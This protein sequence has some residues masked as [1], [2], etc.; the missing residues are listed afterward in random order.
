ML[1]FTGCVKDQP[2]KPAANNPGSKHGVY[3]VCEGQYSAGD[4]SLYVYQPLHDSVFGDLYFNANSKPLGDV[5]QSMEK[6]GDNFFLA[7]NNSNKVAVVTADGAKLIATINIPFPRYILP[8]GG[9]K[10]YV[11]TLYSN[12]IYVINTGSYSVA[13]SISL[14]FSNGEG[15][16][17]YDNYAFICPWDT[18]CSSV[19]KVDINT[20]QIVQA[21]SV[22]GRA[23]HSVLLD[24]ERMLWVLSGNQPK[25]KAA[26]WTKIDPSTGA[27]LRVYNF[28]GDAEP[29]KPALNPTKDTIY[30]IGVNYNGS[31]ANN[32]IYRMGLNDA[33][34]PSQAFIPA[35]D[36]QYFWG[37]GI[38]PATGYIYVGD[39]KG[40]NQKGSVSSYRPDGR[41]AASFNVGVGPG[42]FYFEN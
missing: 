3:V 39:P 22:G 24:K 25:G 36:Y 38:D 35:L 2:G 32:G 18:A 20:N 30:F 19:Y 6:I 34:L 11:S 40:F 37:L 21:I 8:V 12:K 4:A 5:F 7:I 41:K 14:P 26:A 16:C 33:A 17:L 13:D 27:V 23:P 42:Q 9:G 10:A 28:P 15:M 1:L 29:I 31:I